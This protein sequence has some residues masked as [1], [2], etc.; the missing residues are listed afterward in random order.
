MSKKKV[1]IT[2]GV[3]VLIVLVILFYFLGRTD[4]TLDSYLKYDSESNKKL[5]DNVQSLRDT[6]ELLTQEDVDT[7]LKSYS[8]VSLLSD[9]VSKSL[10]IRVVIYSYY[11]EINSGLITLEYWEDGIYFKCEDDNDNIE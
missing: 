11:D 7:L 8:N 4:K 9:S 10:G 2:I 6:D 3:I 1:I 5:T